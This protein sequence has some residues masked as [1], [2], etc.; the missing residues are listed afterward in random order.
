MLPTIGICVYT[1]KDIA[2]AL[3]TCVCIS[4]LLPFQISAAHPS[5]AHT[6]GALLVCPPT[7]L[8]RGNVT[9]ISA[10]ATV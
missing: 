1:S 2:E 4:A 3:V 6:C 7:V 9:W 10:Q 5:G 8:S